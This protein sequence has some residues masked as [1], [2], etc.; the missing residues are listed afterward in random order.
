MA[1]LHDLETRSG[2]PSITNMNRTGATDSKLSLD[3]TTRSRDSRA[4]S[5]QHYR[6]FIQRIDPCK[7]MARFYA[8]SI[9]PTLFGD[10]SLIRNWGRIGTRGQWR[11]DLFQ[12]E[13]QAVD[14]FF[15][16]LR[17]KRRKGY[18]PLLREERP[19]L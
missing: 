10:T 6:L 16:L 13:N 19:R 11:I 5:K 17:Q 18:T 12:H 4:M 9:E 1:G 8:M 2:H 3:A 7:N 15:E 14:F